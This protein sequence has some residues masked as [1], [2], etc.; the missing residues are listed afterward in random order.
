MDCC[1]EFK[2]ISK[3][4][5][6]FSE[7]TVCKENNKRFEIICSDKSE[8][9]C[10]IKID[11]CVYPETSKPRKCD[12]LFVRCKTKDFYFVELKGLKYKD[13]YQQLVET[14]Q[15]I[16]KV[17]N[18]KKDQIYGFMVTSKLHPKANLKFANLQEEFKK[19]YGKSLK[20]ES[21][22]FIFRV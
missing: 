4:D 21:N 17:L 12:C 10:K 20:K 13:A 14:I 22:N 6:C 8:K 9:F 7:G 1:K 2:V 5:N 15:N 16:G 3:N 19:K 18:I 11:K